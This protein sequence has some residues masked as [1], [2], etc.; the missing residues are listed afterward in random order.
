[1]RRAEGKKLVLDIRRR[2][3]VLRTLAGSIKRDYQKHMRGQ[4]NRLKVQLRQ[5]L[6]D[7]TADWKRSIQDA[8]LRQ[9]RADV[10]EELVRLDSHFG[11]FSQFLQST[12]PAGRKMDFLV[13]EMNREINTLGSKAGMAAHRV[14]L[15]KEELEKIREQ[16]Q[17]LE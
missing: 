6:G 4:E 13:Q 16:I 12:E 14:V 10:T 3:T 7:E 8:C 17:N 9:V 5:W 1:M 15:F 11:Q 2:L